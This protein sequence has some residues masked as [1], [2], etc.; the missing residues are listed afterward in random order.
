MAKRGLA[1]PCE[2]GKE[3]EE[4]ILDDM[5]L[6]KFGVNQEKEYWADSDRAMDDI[7]G[8]ELGPELVQGPQGGGAFHGGLRSLGAVVARGLR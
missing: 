3:V 4:A 2:K 1:G 5:D 7:S 8:K 6:G